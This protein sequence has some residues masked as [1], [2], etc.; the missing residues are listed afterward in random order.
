MALTEQLNLSLAL[1]HDRIRNTLYNELADT[2]SAQRKNANTGS[3]ALLYRL[4]PHFSPYV[5]YATSFLPV[6]GSDFFGAQFQ[7][8][9]GKQAEIGAKFAFDN[10]RI[11]GGVAVY[12]LKRRNVTTADPNEEHIAIL[13]SA[14]AQTGEEQTRGFEAEVGADLRNGWDVQAA[15]AVIDA[16]VTGDNGGTVGKRC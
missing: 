3:V 4:P 6:S 12:D 14:Q 11:T 2:T 1:R 10:G 7:P 5:S 13:P 8:E 15:L 9:E 16:V